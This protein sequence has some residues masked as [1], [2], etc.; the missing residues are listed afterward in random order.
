MSSVEQIDFAK[1]KTPELADQVAEILSIS[2]V[3]WQ[4]FKWVCVWLLLLLLLGVLLFIGQ[5]HWSLLLG[6]ICLALVFGLM[7]GI[8]FGAA[9]AIRTG[10]DRL[11]NLF[12]LLLNIVQHVIDDCRD[13]STGKQEIPQRADLIR[14]ALSQVLI[15]TIE[16]VVSNR[17]GFLGKPLL[18]GYR[19]TLG[20]LVNVFIKTSVDQLPDAKLE[21]VDR[22]TE[23]AEQAAQHVSEH[24]QVVASHVS[25]GRDKVSGI[26]GFV[27][28]GCSIPLYLL[29][30]F[31]LMFGLTSLCVLRIAVMWAGDAEPMP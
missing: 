6:A 3:L 24:H 22:L 21:Q 15:P 27:K 13:L 31:F 11:S 25:A 5:A 12:C 14:A 18:W 7:T 26:S 30:A 16:K 9:R 17:L 20:R 4:I 2:A 28:T 10:I 8:T 29:F 19:I 1:Y 23:T